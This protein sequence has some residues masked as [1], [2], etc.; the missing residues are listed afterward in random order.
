MRDG[1]EGAAP[2]DAA[3]AALFVG[4]A[5]ALRCSNAASLQN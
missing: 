4:G 1:T 3:D 5:P 2:E